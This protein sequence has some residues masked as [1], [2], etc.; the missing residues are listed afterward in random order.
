M[1]CHGRR[2]AAFHTRRSRQPACLQARRQHRHELRRSPC[3]NTASPQ[4]VLHSMV[5]MMAICESGPHSTRRV[6]CSAACHRSEGQ[7]GIG[8]EA[9]LRICAGGRRAA[10]VIGCS[11]ARSGR[12]RRRDQGKDRRGTW[13]MI[14]CNQGRRGIRQRATARREALLIIE[15][16][17]GGGDRVARGQMSGSPRFLR[18]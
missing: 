8:T 10:D 18:Q 7:F 1:G 14:G 13:F 9:T 3:L 17:G 12:L 16:K 2:P 4:Y 5:M 11:R 15:A 6:R